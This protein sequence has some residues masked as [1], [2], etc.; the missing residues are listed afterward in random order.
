MKI[1]N[2]IFTTFYRIWFYIIV[3][4]ATILL[5]P[6]LL[7]SILKHSW[8]PFFF[9][10][11]RTWSALIIYGIGCYPIIKRDIQYEKGRSY[12]FVANHTSMTDIMLMFYATKNPF[13]FVGKK[14]LAKI[15][16]F[17]YIYKRTC[18]LVDRGNTKSRV[19][20]FRRAEIRLNEGLSVCIFPEG[21]VPD[22]LSIL[23]DEFKDGAFRLSIE[24]QIPIAPM[25]FHDNKKRFPYSFFIGGP[26][27]MR[28]KVHKLIPTATLTL[29]SRK[30]LKKETREV[31]LN[32]LLAPTV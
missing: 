6:F 18:I 7:I 11:A 8:Y 26:G 16:L 27:K 3:A 17:G 12:M 24:H 29:D 14:E 15:P 32:E 1:F 30:E 10:V 5:F 21:G 28:V 13:V 31:I 25:T 2:Y 23:L 9:K 20:A 22:D 4:I 19:E